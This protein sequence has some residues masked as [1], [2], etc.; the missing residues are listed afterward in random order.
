MPP[1]SASERGPGPGAVNIGSAPPRTPRAGKPGR[2]IGW[3]S[4]PIVRSIWTYPD[5]S[6]APRQRSVPPAVHASRPTGR[7]G[8][9]DQGCRIRCGVLPC[10]HEPAGVGDRSF[11]DAVDGLGQRDRGPARSGPRTLIASSI[12]AAALATSPVLMH[13]RGSDPS[14]RSLSSSWSTTVPAAPL[15][16]SMRSWRRGRA[17]SSRRRRGRSSRCRRGSR[18]A[19]GTRRRRRPRSRH[20]CGRVRRRNRTDRPGPIGVFSLDRRPIGGVDRAVGHA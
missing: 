14:G 9:G 10:P 5:S 1:R 17:R 16:S 11:R 3:N 7:V 19:R 18:P 15:R 4:S 13:R 2:R 20:L 6:T 8:R 12:P